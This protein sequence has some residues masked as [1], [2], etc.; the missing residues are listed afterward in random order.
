[1][2]KF[3]FYEELKKRFANKYKFFKCDINQFGLMLW[4][5]VYSSYKH[6]GVRHI[7]L[8]KRGLQ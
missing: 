1:M 7:Y 8:K 4:K 3:E 2:K 5:G 6:M